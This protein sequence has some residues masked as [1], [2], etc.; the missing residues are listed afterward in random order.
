MSE[1]LNLVLCYPAEQRHLDLYASQLPELEVV[2]AGQEGVNEA[3]P[4]A[5]YFVGHAKVPV[6]WKRVVDAGRLRM[7]QSSA[8]GLDHCLVPEVIASDIPVC[9]ASGLF[10]NQV[11]EQCFALLFG[12]VRSMPTFFRQMQSRDFTRR[13]TDDFHGKKVGIVGLGGNGRRIAEL[14]APFQVE[15]RATDHFPIAKPAE[16]QE[17][18]PSGRLVDLASWSDVLILALPLN[19][20]TRG[21][22]SE[23]V[24]QAMPK[25]SYLI[26]VARGQVVDENALVAALQN[27]H[28]AGAGLDVTEVEPLPH[29]S[30]LWTLP[31]VLISPHVG[32]QSTRRVDDS[33]RL[34][35]QNLRRHLSGEPL[36]NIV[37]K[38]LGF[39][40]PNDMACNQHG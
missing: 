36:I 28:L 1:K 29:D 10:A 24:F 38:S 9:S 2:N 30:P 6:D 13:P 16:V 39:P 26:N 22:I 5:D 11:A 32:A 17:L 23:E 15:I 33:T 18:W 25:G 14:L 4:L 40:H 34:A 20:G 12:L 37:D 3:L 27:G 19:A 31:N 8:A 21:V 35:C 7:I